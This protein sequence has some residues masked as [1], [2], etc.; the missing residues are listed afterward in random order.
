VRRVGTV[1]DARADRLVVGVD[2]LLDRL[3]RGVVRRSGGRRSSRRI[4]RRYRI[5]AVL[6]LLAVFAL[7]AVTLGAVTFVLGIT[8]SGTILPAV[9]GLL[10]IA[11]LL[12]V[13]AGTVVSAITYVLL[14]SIGAKSRQTATETPAK[15]AA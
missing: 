6:A 3:V 11:G 5:L 9:A 12:A 4:A 10:A 13:V 14:K 2:G 15:T 8:I 7:G 1:E